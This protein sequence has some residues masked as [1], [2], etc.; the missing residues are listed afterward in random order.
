MQPFADIA[1]RK[2]VW[3]KDRLREAKE[4]GD[5][6]LSK[7]SGWL[8]ICRVLDIEVQDTK[9]STSC[10]YAPVQ[11]SAGTE[12]LFAYWAP[13]TIKEGGPFQDI[14]TFVDSI[15][16]ISGFLVRLSFHVIC[17]FLPFNHNAR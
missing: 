8:T 13:N 4:K 3:E 5:E 14:K 2:S 7:D 16:A 11:D 17:V 15:V 1:F 12:A 9:G 10:Y 6:T